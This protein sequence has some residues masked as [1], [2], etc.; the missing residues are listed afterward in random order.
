MTEPESP[1]LR[2]EPANQR[3]VARVAGTEAV[4]EYRALDARTLDYQHTFV[5]QSLRGGGVAS[6]L[7]AF[8]LSYARDNDL[9]VRPT[10]PFTARYIERHPEYASLVA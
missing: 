6:Q 7:T 2:H 5:P 1:D 9:K 8:A 10:C 3:F 4:I